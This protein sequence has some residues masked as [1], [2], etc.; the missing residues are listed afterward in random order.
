[1]R[2]RS[3]KEKSADTSRR[4]MDATID[5]LHD[6]GFWRMSTPDIAANAGLSRGALT[7][8]FTGREDIIIR[9]FQ[10]LLQTVTADLNRFAEQL[11]HERGSSD[12]IVDYLWSI[13]NNRLFYIT[14]EILPEARNNG[15]FKRRLVPVVKNFHSGLDAIWST[16][17]RQHGIEPRQATVILNATMCLFRGMIAQTVLRDDPAYFVELRSFWK[18]QVR[19][20]FERLGQRTASGLETPELGALS[21]AES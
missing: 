6:R 7:H 14:M 8:H 11:A 12:D 18:A 19:L 4:L 2:R 15:D 21:L 13:M 1:M 20:T 9:S 3:Q 17:A 16:M 5:L 10:T